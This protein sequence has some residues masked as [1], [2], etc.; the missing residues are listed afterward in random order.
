MAETVKSGTQSAQNKTTGDNMAAA[1]AARSQNASTAVKL[2]ARNRFAL[3]LLLQAQRGCK[4]L[5][6]QVRAGKELGGEPLRAAS[7]LSGVA[8]QAMCED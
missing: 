5:A 7:I 6:G 3:N 8:A 1:R 4:L 2:D